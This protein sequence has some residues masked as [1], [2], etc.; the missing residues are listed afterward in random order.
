M[1]GEAARSEIPAKQLE[2]RVRRQPLL[3]ELDLHGAL[4]S[5]GETELSY[6]VLRQPVIRAPGGD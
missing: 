3:P 1:S 2:A 4:D 5:S 6:P